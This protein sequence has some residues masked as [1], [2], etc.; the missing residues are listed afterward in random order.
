[1]LVGACAW[2]QHI[3]NQWIASNA[4]NTGYEGDL[5]MRLGLL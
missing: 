4:H 2:W 3:A 1:M 5:L